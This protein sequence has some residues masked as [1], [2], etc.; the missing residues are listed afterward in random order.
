MMMDVK[1]WPAGDQKWAT[2]YR[3]AMKGRSVPSSSLSE[4][5]QE[6]LDA[7]LESGVPAGELF[8]D[9]RN[10]AIEDAGEL[11]TADEMVRTSVGG[12]LKPALQE[13]AGTWVGIGVAAVVVMVIRGGWLVEVD[14]AIVLVAVSVAAAF[15]GWGVVR[16]LFAAGRSGSAAGALIAVG[17]VIGAGIASAANL[18]PGHIAASEVPV[19]LLALV[20]LCPGVA[21]LVAV[22][23][24]SQQELRETWDDREWFRRFR[25]GLRARLMSSVTAR[26]HVAEVEQALGWAGTTA[27]TEFGHPLSF[28]REL[29]AVDHVARARQWWAVTAATTGGPLLIAML[30]LTNQSWGVLTVPI[31][32]GVTLFA[33]LALSAGWNDRPRRQSR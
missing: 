22:S 11:A 9:A 24:M 32:L 21:V 23:R 30:I 8:G 5:E 26:D 10:L 16:A 7:I 25:G 14:V 31:A 4:R 1:E 12:G 28:A 2:Q 6:L 18:G 19:L 3:L 27:Y 33:V 29:A 13:I 20:I 15:L 17:L